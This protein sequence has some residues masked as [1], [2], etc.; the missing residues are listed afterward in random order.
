MCAAKAVSLA[1]VLFAA[2][3]TVQAQEAVP[4]DAFSAWT[5]TRGKQGLPVRAKP[6]RD[7]RIVGSI[8]DPEQ[9]MAATVLIDAYRDGWFRITS[10]DWSDKGA[11][12]GWVEARRL[13]LDVYDPML[14][15]RPDMDAPVTA[16]LRETMLNGRSDNPD[17]KVL[18]L[19]ECR[20][21]WKRVSTSRGDGWAKETCGNPVTTCP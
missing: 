3:D 21:A 12:D 7:A 15:L 14:R 16:R 5:L 2:T 8:V 20:G 1:L 17:I 13:M 4:C 19:I 6:A 11:K 9:E 10:E 18:G